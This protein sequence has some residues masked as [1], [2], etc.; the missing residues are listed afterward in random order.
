MVANF[1][2]ILDLDYLAFSTTT[3]KARHMQSLRYLM[4]YSTY[5]SL[6]QTS[7]EGCAGVG[8]LVLIMNILKHRSESLLL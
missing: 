6:K 4:L 2:E 5:C 1:S 8:A 7:V 3:K